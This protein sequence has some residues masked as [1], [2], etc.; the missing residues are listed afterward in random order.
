MK[1]FNKLSSSLQ[2]EVEE[3][4]ELFKVDQ[5]HSFLKVHKLKGP[6][7]G[8]YSFS[9][10]YRIRIVFERLSDKKIALLSVGSHEIYQ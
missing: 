9:V 4:I 2:D 1:R 8:L 5:S 10:N 7:K 6:L 3:K